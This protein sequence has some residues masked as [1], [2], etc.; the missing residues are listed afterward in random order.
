MAGIRYAFVAKARIEVPQVLRRF[1]RNDAAICDDEEDRDTDGAD[2]HAIIGVRRS[3]NLEGVDRRPQPR[4]DYQLEQLGRTVP[5]PEPC[6]GQH[7]ISIGTEKPA[8]LL[9]GI[10]LVN[11]A[12]ALGTEKC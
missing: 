7:L 5:L 3:Q 2:Q 11:L 10:A 8:M 6:L 9:D 12:L 4:V 1:R